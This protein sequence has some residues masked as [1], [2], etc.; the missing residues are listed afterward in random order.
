MDSEERMSKYSETLYFF[1]S[2]FCFFTV[3]QKMILFLLQKDNTEI[4]NTKGKESDICM[5]GPG[6]VPEHYCNI[7]SVFVFVFWCFFVCFVYCVFWHLH[8]W[9]RVSSRALLQHLFCFFYVFW[10]FFSFFCL[11][12]FRHLYGWTMVS[13]RALLQ[14]F[15]CSFCF[16]VFS[17]HST[18]SFLYS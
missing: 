12:F 4:G 13:G 18:I 16:R 3:L 9:T 2:L 15:F 1:S 5:V 14:H 10:C 11:V 8:G 17:S 7:F 6:W